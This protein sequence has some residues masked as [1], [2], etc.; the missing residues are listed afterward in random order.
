MKNNFIVQ[1]LGFMSIIS[2]IL[3]ISKITVYSSMSWWIVIAPLSIWAFFI[4]SIIFLAFVFAL[5]V[6]VI[7]GQ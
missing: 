1:T 5:V 3:L 6:T 7:K 4:L 2:L